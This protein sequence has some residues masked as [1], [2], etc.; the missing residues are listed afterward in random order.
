MRYI[1]VCVIAL[2]FSGCID[3]TTPK[4]KESSDAPP[5]WLFD[6][7][8]IKDKRSAVGCAD[9]HVR[10][11]SE[12]LKLAI[13]RAVEQIAMQKSTSV[14]VVTYRE[15]RSNRLSTSQTASRQESSG[16]DIATRVKDKYRDKNGRICVLVVEQ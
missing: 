15:S 12:Q 9:R 1:T 10:G 7:N 11:E 13:S 2:L 16:H 4:P 3:A 5:A 6:P 14:D 8:Y